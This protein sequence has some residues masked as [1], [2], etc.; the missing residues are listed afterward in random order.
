MRWPGG[1]AAMAP[2]S[3]SAAPRRIAAKASHRIAAP[4]RSHSS[5]TR[6]API[7][8]T[9]ICASMSPRTSSGWRLLARISRSM[10]GSGRPAARIRIGGI[11]TP[12]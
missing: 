3:S 6:A 1:S 9:A 10:S 8:V 11:S 4:K 5:F 2:R 12:S 7:S